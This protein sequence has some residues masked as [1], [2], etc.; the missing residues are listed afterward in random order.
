MRD[1]IAEVVLA[2]VVALL[3]AGCGGGEKPGAGPAEAVV[4]RR[5][6]LGPLGDA[7]NGIALALKF[8]PATGPERQL[9]ITA[10]KWVF[11]D[12]LLTDKERNANREAHIRPAPRDVEAWLRANRAGPAGRVRAPRPAAAEGQARAGAG[13]PGDGRHA[14]RDGRAGRP[15]TG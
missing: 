1:R 8:D 2:G 3:A 7:E 14:V 12:T 15:L 13:V 11:D 9:T 6:G 5:E 4:H 10:V